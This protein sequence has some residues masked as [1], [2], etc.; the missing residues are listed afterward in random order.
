M[1]TSRA[2]EEAFCGAA[3]AVLRDA[4]AA[5][6]NPAVAVAAVE[7]AVVA[8]RACVCVPAA[9]ADHNL[10]EAVEAVRSGAAVCKV[11]DSLP[12]SNLPEQFLL[13]A[14][15]LSAQNSA[16]RISPKRPFL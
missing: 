5:V 16:R 10:A 6:R 11:L 3:V 8:S 15:R 12:R 14:R 1:I 7:G 9:E 13:P 4:E 2:A